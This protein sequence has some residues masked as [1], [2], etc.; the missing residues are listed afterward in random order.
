MHAASTATVA[1]SRQPCLHTAML[2]A[3]RRTVRQQPADAASQLCKCKSA[4]PIHA[5]LHV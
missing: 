5:A 2:Q 3:S 4:F 1:A